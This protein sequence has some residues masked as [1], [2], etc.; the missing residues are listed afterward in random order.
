MNLAPGFQP[1]YQQVYNMLVRRIAE[2]AWRPAES[3]PSEH[4]LAEELGVSQGTVRKA[5]DV[6]AAEKLV[7]R[8]QGKGTYV[9]EHTQELSLFRFFRLSRPNGER[10]TP[11][12]KIESV[13]HRMAKPTEKTKLN[14]R[15]NTEVVEIRRIRFIDQVPTVSEIVIV[16]LVFFP[17]IDKIS[18]LP[19]TLYSLYQSKYGIS[20]I[21]AHEE[22]SA[23]SA[24]K[25]D[26]KR[27]NLP[28]GLPLINIDRVALSIDGK[29]VEWRVSRCDTSN[30]VYGITLN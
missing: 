8:R 10:L 28:V 13:K 27:L 11:T 3:L 14:L 17:G 9:A 22:I 21:A 5:L 1:L 26:A 12:C 15:D 16:P 18:E 19:N 24:T 23:I 7:E 29:Y 6:M 25:G 20:V 30:V 2:G 4:A